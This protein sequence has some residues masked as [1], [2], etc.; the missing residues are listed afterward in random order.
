M[1][2]LLIVATIS[3]ESGAQLPSVVGSTD[4]IAIY[5]EVAHVMRA[6]VEQGQGCLHLIVMKQNGN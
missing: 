1:Q 6:F 4:D 3:K 5:K 2:K